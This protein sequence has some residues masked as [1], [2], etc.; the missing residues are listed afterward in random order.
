MFHV[1]LQT[2]QTYNICVLH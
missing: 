1:I 2:N